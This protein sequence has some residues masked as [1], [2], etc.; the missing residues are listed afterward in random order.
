MMNMFSSPT[1]YA[2]AQSSTHPTSTNQVHCEATGPLNLNINSSLQDKK[3]H[4]PPATIKAE[5]SVADPG[6]LFTQF[7]EAMSLCNPLNGMPPKS[8][9]LTSAD[10][11]TKASVCGMP[12]TVKPE[13]NVCDP[14]AFGVQ[15]SHTDVDGV[16]QAKLES[17]TGISF[18]QATFDDSSTM[19]IN[20]PS[21]LDEG[22]DD[23]A[24]PPK[25]AVNP[26]RKYSSF[27]ECG[28]PTC[29]SSA[30]RE[31]YHC[32]SCN[33]LIIRR[34][35]MIRHAKWHRKREESLQYGFMR[36][37][38][39]D[40]C[41]V[42][43][44]VHNGRQTHYH[45][46]KPNCTKVYISTSD[47]QMHANFHRKDAVI[48]QEGFQRFRASENCGVQGCP[49]TKERTTHFHC[50]RTNCHF[51]F[52]NKADMEKH[53]LH[54]Q[55]NDNFAKDGFRKYIKCESCGFSSCKYSG[56][57]N[58]IHCI[59]PGEFL[60]PKAST[61][62]SLLVAFVLIQNSNIPTNFG[63][64][65]GSPQTPPDEYAFNASDPTGSNMSPEKEPYAMEIDERFEHSGTGSLGDDS[66]P[67]S[68]KTF[69]CAVSSNQANETNMEN[70]R[71]SLLF[72]TVSR[73]V[74][75]CVQYR[76]RNAIKMKGPESSMANGSREHVATK[77]NYTIEYLFHSKEEESRDQWADDT[78]DDESEDRKQ[79][80][81][82]IGLV[83]KHFKKC[84]PETGDGEACGKDPSKV[85]Q[86]CYWPGCC[87]DQNGGFQ[88]ECAQWI[89]H[90]WQA[91]LLR[92]GL[93]R[94]DGSDCPH[95]TGPIHF[96]CFLWP[97]CGFTSPQGDSDFE[98][99]YGHLVQHDSRLS[100][101]SAEAFEFNSSGIAAASKRE[102]NSSLIGI[103]D[104]AYGAFGQ[105]PR[106]RGRPPK[107][108]KYV[109]VPRLNV[110]DELCKDD[111]RVPEINH[112][113]FLATEH[114]DT[115]DGDV[116][117][118]SDLSARIVCGVKL[119]LRNEAC[120]DELCDY[121]SRGVEHYHCIR[122]RCFM[123]SDSL[124][125][126]NVHRR[127]FHSH[128]NIAPGFEH[129]DRS[130]D[131]RRPTCHS[132]RTA[133][134]YHCTYPNCD[135]SFI[136]PSTMLQHARKHEEL[137]KARRYSGY[138][139]SGLNGR[140]KQLSKHPGNP[141][142]SAQV[143]VKPPYLPLGMSPMVAAQIP[144]FL[145]TSQ[146]GVGASLDQA[147]EPVFLPPTNRM[148]AE[149]LPGFLP[150]WAAAM[151]AAAAVT[152]PNPI[153]SLLPNTSKED[154]SG[155]FTGSQDATMSIL[156]SRISEIEETSV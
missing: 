131:C 136:R 44:C 17:P 106:R 98:I 10:P 142:P 31:H 49:F 13:T 15:S 3:F 16:A 7:P 103:T 69:G 53:K 41:T 43:E 2:N 152:K 79:V 32:K 26:I 128:I 122:P 108:T 129:F 25:P 121:S 87:A 125:M 155:S 24:I 92:R 46:V 47:V 94:C 114:Q 102:Q 124:D 23:P 117:K 91:T 99:L 150:I 39:S 132:R 101:R 58:H 68:N 28:S 82:I 71:E 135:Y 73:L 55:K 147:P 140:E 96:H 1:P 33:K 139:V 57:I 115:G 126:M 19:D 40:N 60:L 63:E 59:R 22:S 52:K 54:H 37:S 72:Y 14:F 149:Q 78:D 141:K 48:I 127:E 35:E 6:G 146:Q 64:R 5:C 77:P 20:C 67:T 110:P 154:L 18:E 34:E 12:T 83:E 9:I 36:Y 97:E 111:P 4:W 45:C 89:N 148:N 61:V 133:Q 138:F 105:M 27:E 76:K 30:L 70:S 113:M 51:T 90:I 153:P 66:L 85:H 84:T 145:P 95:S 123:T 81:Q 56:I 86:H 134:H 88:N 38:P 143:D 50:R 116:T 119:F 65:R 8:S 62:T 118:E 80:Q 156:D 29:Q 109:R 42:P 151:A 120:Q 137:A 21:N 104:T 107:Y 11:K 93:T 100:T 74:T 75:R 112:S 144:S 130:V